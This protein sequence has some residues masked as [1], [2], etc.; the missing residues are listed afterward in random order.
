M[1]RLLAAI[2][3]G[4]NT[5]RVLVAEANPATGLV[6]QW[7]DQVVARLGE[8]V[9][10]LGALAPAAADRALAAVPVTGTALGGWGPPRSSWSR[11][12]PSARLGTAASSSPACG[13]NP[14]SIPAS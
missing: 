7:A 4:T 10:G 14:G 11:P 3:L 13:Q 8:G 9:A 6:P 1:T 12:P 5:V 2:D